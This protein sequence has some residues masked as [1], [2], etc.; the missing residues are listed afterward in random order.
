[1]GM[2]DAVRGPGRLLLSA[3]FVAGGA[4]AILKPE[5]AAQKAKEEL[6]V[7]KPKLAARQR[8]RH[9]GGRHDDRSRLPAAVLVGSLVLPT[10]AGHPFW[11]EE[12]EQARTN[13]QNHFFKNLAL[14]GAAH[15]RR[16]STVSGPVRHPSLIGCFRAPVLSLR[17]GRAVLTIS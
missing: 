7:P 10:L 5:W 9:G 4:G 14:I 8:R 2:L 3:V 13:Q 12:D 17:L 16:P 6:D 15:L 1:M 11:K